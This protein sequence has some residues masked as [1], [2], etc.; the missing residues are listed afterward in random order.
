[1]KKL[2]HNSQRGYFCGALLEEMHVNKDIVVIVGDLGY[3]AFDKIKETYP[4][5]FFNVGASEQAMVGIACGMALRGK[6]PVVYSITPFLLTRPY[7]WLRNYVN[8]E[9]TPICLVGAGRD[10]DYKHD[11]FTHYA[12]DAK[13]I[14]DTLPNI[15]QF[16]PESKESVVKLMKLFLYNKRP[17]FMSLTR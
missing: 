14:L 8:H 5:R 4:Q 17:T 12:T 13:K 15:V 2:W 6:I 9:N 11:G 3:G 16:Y 10:E 1:M 7:E